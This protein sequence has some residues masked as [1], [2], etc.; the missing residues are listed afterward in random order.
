MQITSDLSEG[1][2]TKAVL[3]PWPAEDIGAE[4]GVPNSNGCAPALGGLGGG[5][6][7][8]AE[9]SRPLLC[10]VPKDNTTMDNLSDNAWHVEGFAPPIT[11]FRLS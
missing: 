8:V 1:P 7:L 6:R 5:Q 11:H 3:R 2:G 10:T 4:T 9:M